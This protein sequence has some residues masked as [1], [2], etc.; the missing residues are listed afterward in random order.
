MSFADKQIDEEDVMKKPYEII[1]LDKYTRKIQQP[2]ILLMNRS[3]DVIGKISRYEDWRI[4]LTANVVDEIIFD[5]HKYSDGRLC[6]VWDDLVDLKIIDVSGFGRFEISVDYTDNT[7]TVKSIHGFSLETELA[8]VGLYEF[9]VND[10]EAAD[11]EITEYS[12]DNYKDGNFIPTVFYNSAAPKHSLLHRVLADKAPHWS[13]GYVTPY[14]AIDEE[15]QPEE[16]SKF[17]RTYTVDG[18]SIYDFLTGTV[19]KESNV[20]FVFDTINRKI[21]CYS[22]CDCIDQETG[23]ILCNGIGEDTTVF[24]SKNKLANEITISSN[25]DNVKN[26]FRIEGGD[27][28]ITDMVRAVNMNGSNY[29]YQFADFQYNDMSEALR[30]KITDYQEMMSSKETQEEYY[31]ENGIYT[32]LCNAYDDLAYYESSMMP[33]TDKVTEP[34]TAKAQYEKIV[35]ELTTTN[36]YVAVSSVNNYN[37]NLFAGITNNIEAYAQVFLDS[38]FDL[39]VVDGSTSYNDSTKTWTGKI[40]IVQHT[41]EKNIYPVDTTTSA[42]IAVKINDDEIEFAKQKVHKAL[43]KS[44]MADID[45]NVAGMDET[46][47]RNYFNQYAL[48]RLKSFEDG[49]NSCLS[50]LADMGQT[51]ASDVQKTLYSE[52]EQRY[53]IVESIRR[54][55]QKKVDSINTQM[56]AIRREQQTFQNEHNFQSFLGDELYKEFCAYRREDT[57][58][59]SNYISDG[60]STAECLEKARELVEVA[61]KEAKK[62]CVLQRT[63]STSLNNLFALPEFEPLYDKF[64]LFNYIRIRTEDEI[65]K[66]R[67]IGVEFSG[68]SVEEIQVTFSEQ[69]ES[70]DGKMSDLQSIIQQASSMA[71]SYQ[72]TTLQAKQG[73]NANNEI[74]D[75][76]TNGLSAAKTMLANNDNNEVTITQAG[77]LCKRMDDEGSY[78]DKQLRITGNIIALTEDGWKTVKTAI[79]E[80]TFYNPFTKQYEMKYG[81][82]APAIVGELIC[83]NNVFIGNEKGNVQIT[84]NGITIYDEKGTEDENKVFFADEE[85][86]LTLKGNVYASGGSIGGLH[87]SKNSISC[88]LR[89]DYE[90][91]PVDDN[92]QHYY[93]YSYVYTAIDGTEKTVV[94]RAL[95]D[96]EVSA[97]KCMILENENS[98]VELEENGYQGFLNK[99]CTGAEY[100]LPR[101]FNL[102]ELDFVFGYGTTTKYYHLKTSRIDPAQVPD[103]S[104]GDEDIIGGGTAGE[105]LWCYEFNTEQDGSGDSFCLYE[106]EIPRSHPFDIPA[107]D[108]IKEIVST[109]NTEEGT[110]SD[111]NS[112]YIDQNR[113][114]MGETASFDVITGTSQIKNIDCSLIPYLNGEYNLGSPYKK[115]NTIYASSPTIVT[116]DRNRKY[117]I[118][119]DMDKYILLFD[120]LKPCSFIYIDGNSSRRHI[121]YIAQDVEAAMQELGIDNL[122]FAGLCKDKVGGTEIYSLRYDEFQGI[123]DAKIK[124][125]DKQIKECNERIK[126][127][128]EQVKDMKKRIEN[129]EKLIAS[130]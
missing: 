69:I 72:S 41:D 42:Y 108:V 98:T 23:E 14:I 84:G 11:M 123:Y 71:T 100:Y 25:K 17:Q 45:F 13:I 20:I 82:K 55:R 35:K 59:N 4:Y 128:D 77:I 127:R 122:E 33:N 19:A 114:S 27:D 103:V 121:G 78:G 6:P 85:G 74:V 110:Y 49:Y 1:K 73:A 37:N 62:A 76:Y 38:R 43:S 5:V 86:N 15:S 51:T 83:G 46:G 16:S 130:K 31:G 97:F 3:F 50:I 60:L 99:E 9:H 61:T 90:K 70:V 93:D 101:Y 57:Y 125:C 64:A 118:D 79:G 58:T 104:T 75:M 32:R 34:G 87:V 120:K 68:D 29:I 54:E 7:E 113:I 10:D 66:L 48:N 119:Y 89:I 30:Q 21:N 24:V 8:Q 67:L 52:Y 81:I 116:S 111:K 44:T 63:V 26:C 53:R 112:L 117:K 56:E 129:L 109:M 88:K 36:F 80:S 102:N 18:D 124:Q 91:L 107:E 105:I 65:L 94:I 22:L 39:S 106:K 126:K 96:V 95:Y 2:L 92:G 40:Q 115:W 47:M 28:V 12:K